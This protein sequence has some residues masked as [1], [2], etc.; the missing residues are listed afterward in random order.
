MMALLTSSRFGLCDYEMEQLC[1]RHVTAKGGGQDDGGSNR[2]SCWPTLA[3]FLGPFLQRTI[4][5]GLGLLTWRDVTLR[6]QMTDTFLTANDAGQVHRMMLDY[7]WAIWTEARDSMQA[8]NWAG[9]A[10]PSSAA[11]ALRL[12]R[13]ALDEIPYHLSHLND[14]AVA[15]ERWKS[16]WSWDSGWLLAKLAASGVTQ[17]LEDVAL[18]PEELHPPQSL[19]QLL[20][21]SAAALDYDF[22]QLGGQLSGRGSS[23]PGK[24]SLVPCL[25]PS[26]PCLASSAD[27]SAEVCISAIYR[28]S[29]GEQ[30][31]AA[32]LS[33]VKDE[34]SLWDFSTGQCDKGT[35]LA[36]PFSF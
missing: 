28:L 10:T 17:V 26:G 27:Q 36:R 6:Q 11:N 15:S 29:D 24:I 20:V 31:R 18:T 1:R 8:D 13:R 5:G 32:A 21:L 9:L 7:Y 35:R 12:V 34:M 19:Q 25:M 3:Y 4:V 33:A 22:R 2:T 23:L 14:P 16:L 30:Y